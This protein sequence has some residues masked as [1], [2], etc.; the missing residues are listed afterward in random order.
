MDLPTAEF[1]KH[2]RI[3]RLAS[4]QSQR[5]TK[6]GAV[7]FRSACGF[8]APCTSFT[9]SARISRPRSLTLRTATCHSFGRWCLS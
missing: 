5:M 3:L 1:Q 6:H 8:P 7:C 9:V 2:D 4:Q